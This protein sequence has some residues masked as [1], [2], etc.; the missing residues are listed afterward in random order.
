MSD[1]TSILKL[2]NTRRQVAYKFVVG[3]VDYKNDIMNTHYKLLKML[4]SFQNINSTL[5]YVRRKATEDLD[6]L[7][8]ND[9]T[10]RV[11]RNGHVI[12]PINSNI[13]GDLAYLQTGDKGFVASGATGEFKNKDGQFA[14]YIGKNFNYDSNVE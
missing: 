1:T 6:V 14:I 2:F 7:G 12:D 13:K 4:Q 3:D 10:N 9:E 5:Q 8:F 11:W